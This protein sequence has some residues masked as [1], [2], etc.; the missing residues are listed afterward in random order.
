GAAGCVLARPVRRWEYVGG[1][2]AGIAGVL[3]LFTAILGLLLALVL[4]GR[5]TQLG[6]S[7]VGLRIFGC[8]CALQWLKLTLVSALTLLVGSYACSTL[9]AS[10]A[11][12]LLALIAHLRPFAGGGWLTWLRAWPNL[13]L[14]D[15]ESLLAA[16]A[17]PA[18]AWLLQLTLYWAAYVL[19][20]GALASHVFKRR[21]L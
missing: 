14:F 7:A 3:A 18:G 9:F 2:F 19:V 15:S 13:A 17:A 5:G 1:K 20:L 11:G 21:E 8:A 12:L 6:V 10:C 16:G 4:A